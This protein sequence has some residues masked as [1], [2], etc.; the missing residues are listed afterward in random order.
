MAIKKSELY[1]SL[2]KSCDELRGG[3]DAS[4]Y[5]DYV[6]ILLFVKYVSD[7][8]AGD[9][10]ALIDVPTGGSFAD[11]VAAKGDKEIGDKVNK[12]IGRLEHWCLYVLQG[13]LTELKKVDQLTQYEYLKSK[14]LVPALT[15]ARNRTLITAQEEAVLLSTVKSGVAKAAD[16]SAAMPGMSAAQRTYQIKK[17]VER[18]MLHP[19]AP[20]ARQ[21][22]L[23][24]DNSYLM[25]GVIHALSHESFI[26]VPL[27][28]QVPQT[29][30]APG[31][32]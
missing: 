31:K 14:I 13:V 17:L 21:Y 8:Y 12:I 32:P 30:S 2:W 9:P 28:G 18:K 19:I 10:A 11:M 29:P 24:F 27:T 16:L 4:Q 5:K 25:R 20:N 26:S 15:Y 3:M 23:G 1:S 22:T 6:L 7:K